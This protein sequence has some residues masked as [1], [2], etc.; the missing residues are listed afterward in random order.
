MLNGRKIDKLSIK[1]TNILHCKT[2]PKC[3]KIPIFGQKINHLA[4]LG[5]RRHTGPKS[6][7]KSDHEKF[8]HLQ[9]N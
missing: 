7:K 6:C 8:I 4:T 2:S 1:Y 9:Q 5:P 3:T